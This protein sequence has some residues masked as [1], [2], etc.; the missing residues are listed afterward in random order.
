MGCCG[1]ALPLLLLPP[2]P[3]PLLE[4]PSCL[5]GSRSAMPLGWISAASA[6]VNSKMVPPAAS[7]RARTCHS[8]YRS[9]VLLSGV[10][11]HSGDNYLPDP[12]THAAVQYCTAYLHDAA[13]IEP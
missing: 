13:R 10:R 6:A 9:A 5:G 8:R 1:A 2:L 7:K 3:L 11:Y 12:C 4:A